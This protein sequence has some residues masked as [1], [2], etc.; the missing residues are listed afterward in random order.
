MNNMNVASMR[1]E[2]A[3]LAHKDKYGFQQDDVTTFDAF[4]L[5]NVRFREQL[6]DNAIQCVNLQNNKLWIFTA[7]NKVIVKQELMPK[8]DGAVKGNPRIVDDPSHLRRCKF[9][10]MFVD[11]TGSHCFMIADHEVFYNHWES[12]NIFKVDLSQSEGYG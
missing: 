4:Q 2:T 9:R 10:K 3:D 6:L 7:K 8:G 11:A 5:E 12:D 1:L